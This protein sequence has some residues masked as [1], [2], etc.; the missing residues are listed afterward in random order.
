M[1][2]LAET[3]IT[4]TTKQEYWGKDF[5]KCYSERLNVRIDQIEDKIYEQEKRR[6]RT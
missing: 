1:R 3:E 5:N 6:K 4:K 2:N